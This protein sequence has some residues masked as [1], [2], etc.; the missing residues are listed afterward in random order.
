[1][2]VLVIGGSS[3]IGV[4]TVDELL[5]RGDVVVATGRNKKFSDHYASLEVNYVPLDITSLD[6]FE[7]IDGCRPDVVINLAALMPANIEKD[8]AEDDT[9][10]Y[11]KV[12]VLGELNILSWCRAHGVRRL[13]D[14]VSRFDVRLYDQDKIIT[15]ETPQRF[16]YTDDH[17][18]YVMSNNGKAEMMHYYNEKYGMSN[19]WLRIPS[20]YGVGPHGSFSKDG[21]YRKSGLQI[22]MD[23]ASAGE[24]IEVYGDP[25]TPKDVMYVKDMAQAIA[26]AVHAGNDARGLYNVSY[27]KNFS[28][29]TLAESVATAFEGKAGRSKVV[30]RP[31][32]ANNGGFPLMSNEKIKRELGFSPNFGEPLAMM[33]DF[34]MELDRGVYGPLFGVA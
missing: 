1:M 4:Y 17:A 32:V 5:R 8:A 7:A 12:N 9:A 14:I 23:K 16:S 21:T 24:T 13:V 31:E 19:I 6:S 3:F 15:E 27:D 10:D 26:C 33:R 18:A 30:S 22:F 25:N 20:V 29:F 28:I 34:K 2:K 11:I